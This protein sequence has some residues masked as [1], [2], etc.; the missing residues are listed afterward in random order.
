MGAS[1]NWG[2]GIEF[3]R[4]QCALSPPSAGRAGAL[5]PAVQLPALRRRLGLP[6]VLRMVK[7]PARE[8][9]GLILLSGCH[10]ATE[11]LQRFFTS[12]RRRGQYPCT[13]GSRISTVG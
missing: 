2:E 13:G 11:E 8:C 7:A 9:S 4:A 3:G 1:G 10:R 6:A 12:A 5:S